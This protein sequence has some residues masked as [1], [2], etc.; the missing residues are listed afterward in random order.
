LIVVAMDAVVFGNVTLD[1]ICLTVNDVPRYES[2]LFDQ[3]AVMPGGC[4]SNV[5]FGLGTLGISTALI[6]CIGDDAPG[7][8]LK[9]F[10]AKAGINLEFV[11]QIKNQTT[12]VSIGLIDSDAQPRFVHTPGANAFLNADDLDISLLIKEKVKFLHIGGFFV[13]PGVSH[14]RLPKLLAIARQN[15]IVTT[16]DVVRS[17]RMNDPTPLWPCMPNLDIFLCNQIESARLSGNEDLEKASSFLRNKGVKAVIVK[18]GSKGC[19]VDSEEFTGIIPAPNTT[20]IDTT[21]AGDAFAAG[22]IAALVRGKNLKEACSEGNQAGAQMV[23]KI[24]AIGGWL[25]QD[26]QI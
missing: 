4:G 24:G 6:C 20:A 23:T 7:R 10:W 22:M 18:L 1:I 13:L 21:G 17:V 14:E 8:I 3:V 9:D 5:A 12:A 2:L 25:N 15:G 19:W 26:N 16:L 11:K